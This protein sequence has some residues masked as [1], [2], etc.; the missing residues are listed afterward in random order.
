M[1]G[2]RNRVCLAL[3]GQRV[4]QCRWGPQGEEPVEVKVGKG[5]LQEP[6]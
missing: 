1:Q 2:G 5:K 4:A 3:A 6:N